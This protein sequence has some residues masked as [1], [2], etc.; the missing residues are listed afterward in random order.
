MCWRTPTSWA[1]LEPFHGAGVRTVVV[2]E[3]GVER[4]AEQAGPDSSAG[5]C[6]P[7]VKRCGRP[8]ASALVRVVA[9]GLTLTPCQGLDSVAP[10]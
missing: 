7:R 2:D 9:V 4:E 6:G 1:V 5:A 10:C 8:A 3:D